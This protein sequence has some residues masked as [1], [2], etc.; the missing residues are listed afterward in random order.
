MENIPC[1]Y[2]SSQCTIT[3]YVYVYIALK[4]QLGQSFHMTS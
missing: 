1:I 2:K 3:V 4:S